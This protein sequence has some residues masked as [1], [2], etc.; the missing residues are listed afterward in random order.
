MTT[1]IINRLFSFLPLNSV[2]PLEI[3]T[4]DGSGQSSHPDVVYFLTALHGFH[5]WMAMTSY[6]SGIA[7]FENPSI[8][9]SNDGILWQVP[10]GLINPIVSSHGYGKSVYNSDAV[11]L[12]NPS[13]DELWCYYRVSSS[14]AYDKIYQKVSSDG[15]VWSEAVLCLHTSYAMV[16]S[17]SISK[18][19]STYYMWSVNSMGSNTVE[20]RISTDGVNWSFPIKCV[21]NGLLPQNKEVWHL[22]VIYLIEHDEYWMLL[23]V[24]NI[25]ATGAGSRLMFA[26]SKDRINWNVLEG[27]FIDVG[28]PKGSWDDNLV[29][30]GS[31]VLDSSTLKIWYSARGREK[32]GIGYTTCE[33]NME[34]LLAQGL[35]RTKDIISV[36][37]IIPAYNMEKF[38]GETIKSIANQTVRPREIIVVDDASTDRTGR[39][40]CKEFDKIEGITTHLVIHRENKG[41]GV[42]RQDGVEYAKSDYIAFLSADDVYDPRFLELSSQKLSEKN[43]TFTDYYCWSYLLKNPLEIFKAPLSISQEDFRSDVIKWAL[44]KNMFVMFSA[45]VMPKSWFE[46]IGFEPELR[47]GEDLIFLLDTIIQKFEWLHIPQPLVYYRIHPQQGTRTQNKDEWYLLW[48]YNMKRLRKLGLPEKT[49]RKSLLEN[50]RRENQSFMDKALAKVGRVVRRIV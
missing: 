39:V 20:L 35:S 45:I 14:G 38:I 25:G 50:N 40:V 18:I 44:Q 26:R 17:P 24:C 33:V 22:D 15:I 47:H 3:P 34:S 29:Y 19:G 8:L 32:W 16:L 9:V 4:Y 48:D 6:P 31:M 28:R 42:S 7:S 27:W 13:T 2:S 43:G 1:T 37:V 21:L 41:I 46:K 49:I 11:L 30:R 36:S 12:Y 5:Y 10:S 23:V